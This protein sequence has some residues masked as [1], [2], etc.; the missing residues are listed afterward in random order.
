MKINNVKKVLKKIAKKLKLIKSVKEQIVIK[1]VSAL[2]SYLERTDINELNKIEDYTTLLAHGPLHFFPKNNAWLVTGYTEITNILSNHE[3]FST[4]ELRR[5]LGETDVLTDINNSEYTEFRSLLKNYFSNIFFKLL[6]EYLNKKL[7]I[8]TE[9]ILK[10]D[11]I[12]FSKEF[13]HNVTTETMRYIFGLE[14]SLIVDENNEFKILD[15]N[16]SSFFDLLYI[17]NNNL[18]IDK[19]AYQ[20]SGLI[21]KNQL[22]IAEAS[23]I[24]RIIWFSGINSTRSLITRMMY[25]TISNPSLAEKIYSNKNL[26]IKFIEEC[27]RL[28]PSFHKII[29]ICKTDTII[30]NTLIAKGSKIY[31]DIFSA[32]RD[33]NMF[34]EPNNF[35]LEKNKNRH[36]TFS[37]GITQCIGMGLARLEA[38]IAIE[39]L[40]EIMPFA[41]IDDFKIEKYYND[42]VWMEMFEELSLNIKN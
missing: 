30:N 9:N 29:R 39:Y 19:L 16:D 13:S 4:V 5:V 22:S 23:T 12:D 6:E 11:K 42:Q 14:R 40:L 18:E 27:L 31:L 37:F 17:E 34:E 26:Q 10:K 35:S 32:N 24:S 21:T 36:I 33:E 1:P 3:I 41:K 15:F 7:R 20:I 8:I 25:E 38:K 2:Q 28:Y